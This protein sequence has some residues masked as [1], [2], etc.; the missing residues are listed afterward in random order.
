[1]FEQ[2]VPDK[3]DIKWKG[4]KSRW[5]VELSTDDLL[6]DVE[7]KVRDCPM[8]EYPNWILE[9]KKWFPLKARKMAITDKALYANFYSPDGETLDGMRIWDLDED[10]IGES[11]IK[12][13]SKTTVY[14][15]E[16]VGKEVYLLDPEDAFVERYF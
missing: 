7:I 13:C 15:A 8:D 10:I 6:Y 3:F 12:M 14:D 11:Q 4:D 5:D 1:M 2:V 9:D 16:K